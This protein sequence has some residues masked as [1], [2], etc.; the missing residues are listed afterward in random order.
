MFYLKFKKL[1]DGTGSSLLCTGF[2]QL[3]QVRAVLWLWCVGFSLQWLFLLR[4]VGSRAWAQKVWCTGLVAPSMW[5]F[6]K[7]GIEPTSPVLS[8]RF[9]TTG[10]PGKSRN[11]FCFNEETLG[12]LL[13][14]FGME[15]G[16][17]KHKVTIRS[18]EFSAPPSICWEGERGWRRN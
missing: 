4:S 5:N 10:P 8:G 3:W 14:S 18:L 7:P 2:L 11:V 1:I 15:P 9:L 6:P 13:D 16:H 12:G 17:Q